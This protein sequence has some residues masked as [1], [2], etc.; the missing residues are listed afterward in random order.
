MNIDGYHQPPA[1]PPLRDGGRRGGSD[2]RIDGARQRRE[3]EASSLPTDPDNLTDL[4]KLHVPKVTLPPVVE[5]GSQAPIVVE[6]D[7][8]MDDDHYIK[9][10]QILNFDDPI[11]IKGKFY[12]TPANGEVYLGTQI[13]LDGG[14]GHGVGHRRVQP[15][16]PLGG[17]P[18]CQG[19]GGRLLTREMTAV[20]DRLVPAI[21]IRGCVADYVGDSRSAS[22]AADR[23][24][25]RLGA[26]RDPNPRH[27]RPACVSP[28]RF[29]TATSTRSS[30]GGGSRAR[31]TTSPRRRCRAGSAAMANVAAVIE[32]LRAEK[33]GRTLLL[34]AGDTWH[35]AGLSVFD[36]GVTMVNIMNAMGYDAM[37]P[38]NWEFIYDKEH[39][40]DLIDM[41]EFPRRRLQRDR[42]RVGRAG[43]PAVRNQ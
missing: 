14:E 17:Q 5:D 29:T 27:E 16:R 13:R 25:P 21:A 23:R 24:G 3:G 38:G 36:R 4:E 42:P 2:V 43:V 15:A 1:V 22:A 30:R 37:A 32:R 39:L 10:V 9:S 28:A 40:L 34:D 41:A 35:G 11:V 19:R 6:M 8:P 18:E 26:G 12:L 31:A 7:H 33:P 20:R